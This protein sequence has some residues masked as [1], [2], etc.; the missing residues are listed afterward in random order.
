MS[1][2]L[3]ETLGPAPL[4]RR[5]AL[6]VRSDL[7]PRGVQLDVE[8]VGILELDARIARRATT[9]FVDDRHTPGAEKLADLEQLGHGADLQ[10][11]VVKAGLP[12]SAR[13]EGALGRHQRDG[14]M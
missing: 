8:P 4:L 12:L 7:T 3:F 5:P 6:A 9:S 13:L 2:G 14:V 11:A 10:G 1:H